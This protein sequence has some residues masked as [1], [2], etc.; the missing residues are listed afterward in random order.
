MHHN[1]PNCTIYKNFLGG[2][3]PSNPPSK[4]HGYAMR[5]MSRRDMQIFKSQ[6][7]ILAPPSQI[8]G[9]P[10]ISTSKYKCSSDFIVPGFNE[11]VR[12]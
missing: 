1:A 8:L 12:D 2:G 5:S 9:T 6:K 3:M 7:K 4:A 11:Y 10:L